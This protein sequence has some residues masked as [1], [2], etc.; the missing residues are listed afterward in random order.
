ME[1]FSELLWGGEGFK[2]LPQ[3]SEEKQA[4]DVFITFLTAATKYLTE[5][6]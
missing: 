3:S 2:E 1:G 4:T 5:A 6:T